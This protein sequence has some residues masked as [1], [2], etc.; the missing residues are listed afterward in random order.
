MKISLLDYLKHCDPPDPETYNM[1]A[2]KFGMVRE[3]ATL[4]EKEGVKKL[5]SVS[6]RKMG[7]TPPRQEIL[8]PRYVLV[9]SY[10]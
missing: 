1:V 9:M 10:N 8:L 3:I 4:L 6:N 5:N 7:K 2:V